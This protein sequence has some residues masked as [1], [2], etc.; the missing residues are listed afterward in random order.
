ME[1]NTSTKLSPPNPI[2]SSKQ[3]P[4][5]HTGTDQ[6]EDDPH[7]VGLHSSNQSWKPLKLGAEGEVQL[8]LQ[9]VDVRVL[10]VLEEDKGTL[11]KPR[12]HVRTTLH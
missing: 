9:V 4:P 7:P 8:P 2:H 10:H 1:E 5:I 12:L 3:T 11:Q 6:N